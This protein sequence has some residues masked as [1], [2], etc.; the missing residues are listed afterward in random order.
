MTAKDIS[1]QSLGFMARPA[2][3]ALLALGLAG[4]GSSGP[5][6]TRPPDGWI[7]FVNAGL[8]GS[9]GIYLMNPDGGGRRRISSA[10]GPG[11]SWSPDGRQIVFTSNPGISVMNADGSD[12]TRL[13]ATGENP[14]WSPDGQR[15]AFTFRPNE[16]LTEKPPDA[17][18][19]DLIKQEHLQVMNAD[20]SGVARLTDGPV[21]D[22]WPSWSADG[23]RVAF[24]RNP[25]ALMT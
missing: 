5:A 7:V 4:C 22:E 11:L 21:S 6:P 13:T 23:T 8:G 25:L 9:E 16:S 10:T 19:I 14:A 1:R 3:V 24:D 12:V 2:L 17:A 18:A 15:I 20:G